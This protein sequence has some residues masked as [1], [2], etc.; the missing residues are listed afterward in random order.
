MARAMK[1]SGIPWI[2]KIP[3]E[4]DTIKLC[5]ISESIFLGRTPEYSEVPN[6]NQTIGQ[7]NNQ[8]YGIDLAGIKYST[9]KHASECADSEYLKF[10]DILLN[11]LGT[12]SVGRIGYFNISGGRF[13]TDGHIIVIRPNKETNGK[14]IYYYLSTVRKQL[15]DSAVGSTN[16]AFLTVPKIYK[17]RIPS[18][19]KIE[20]KRIVEFLDTECA[21]SDT[22][23]EQTRASIEE[24][25]KL[26][27]SI[28]TEA[29]TKGIRPNRPMK[30]SGIPWIGMIPMDWDVALLKY[31]IRWK[32][33]KGEPD[34]QVLSLYRD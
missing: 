33:V 21:R 3:I 17:I 10:G 8:A 4:W 12:G 5:Y 22:V 19:S 6:S 25:K 11:S 24:Y 23:M 31:S 20:Q 29:V 34:A 18:T 26:K 16:Q 7:K 1:D 9:D 14:F 2:G 13:L 32:S 28:I 15:E 27:Q 30:D